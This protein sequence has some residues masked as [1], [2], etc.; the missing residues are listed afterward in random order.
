MATVECNKPQSEID[1]VTFERF[2]HMYNSLKKSEKYV[3]KE[4]KISFEYFMSSLFPNVYNNVKKALNDSY[5]RGYIDGMWTE[6][7]ENRQE[8]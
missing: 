7:S 3:D 2:E 6:R 1:Y 8:Q 5:T 4:T